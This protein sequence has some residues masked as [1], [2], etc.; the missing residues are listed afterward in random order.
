M[1]CLWKGKMIRCN[2]HCDNMVE[3][4]FVVVMGTSSGAKLHHIRTRC[5]PVSAADTKHLRDKQPL[6]SHQLGCFSS[7]FPI[8]KLCRMI[9]R[10]P[11][12]AS[13]LR[14]ER[15]S[16]ALLLLCRRLLNGCGRLVGGHFTGSRA[17]FQHS[18]GDISRIRALL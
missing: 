11:L 3:C 4:Q 17:A 15:A 2:V 13:S 14:G 10:F 5:E 18:S 12:L 9:F 1:S 8:Q 6:R 7:C 16:E